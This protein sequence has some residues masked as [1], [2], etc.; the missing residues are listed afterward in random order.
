MITDLATSMA[1]DL[2]FAAEALR[3]RPG[4]RVIVL[5]PRASREDMIA[6]LRAHVFACFTV[7]FD[8]PAI[9]DMI[10]RALEA[11]NWRDGI[12]VVSGL[13]NW[14]TLRVASHLLTAERLMR[15]MAEYQSAYRRSRRSS[16]IC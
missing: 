3:V 1:E 16:A 2:A 9:V 11:T 14:F 13:P 5:A 7:P 4:V 15:F 8:Y 10:R 6:S 12:E